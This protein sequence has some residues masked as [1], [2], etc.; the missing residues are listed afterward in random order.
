M[1][2][3]VVLVDFE[4]V[5]PKTV[6]SLG[7]G[8]YQIK[9]FVGARQ[10]KIPLGTARALQVFGPDAEYVQIE[11]SG[12]NA[13]DFHIAFYI[14]RFA[15]GN[16]GAHF[17]VVSEDT[18]FDPLIKH[19]KALGIVCERVK[20]IGD[21][22]AAAA[23]APESLSAKVDAVIGNLEKRKSAKPRTLKTL[24]STIRALFPA[25]IEDEEVERLIEQLMERGV[26][27]VMDGKVHYKP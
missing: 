18:G 16:P 13:L 24:R 22:A 1:K 20:S 12:R 6:G 19:L 5:Q 15:N 8:A 10:S 3:H 14:G 7:G 11:G 21:V 25:P 23:S 2:T 9:V 17:H 27:T 26:I 4:N